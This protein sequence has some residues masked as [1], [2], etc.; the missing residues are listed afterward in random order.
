MPNALTGDFEAVLEVSGGTLDRLLATM[1]Q[2]AFVNA[3]KPSLPHDAYFRIGDDSHVP[4]VRGSVAA[5]IGVPHVEL[6][7]GAADRFRIHVDVRARYRADPGSTPLADIIHGTVRAEYQFEDIDP[8]CFGWRGIA[9]EYLWMRVIKDS[10]SFDGILRNESSILSLIS[11]L[12][13]Q[14]V[15]ARVEKLLATLLDIRFAPTPQPIGKQFRHLRS[16]AFGGGSGQSGIAM[17]FGLSSEK[18]VGDLASINNL[19]LGGHDFGIAVSRE[20]IISSIQPKLDPLVGLQRDFHVHGDAGVG[21]G[22]EIDYHVRLDSTTAEWAGP[23]AIPF[24]PLSGGLIRIR[25]SGVGWASRLYRSGVFNVGS[26]RASDLRMSFTVEQLLLLGFDEGSERLTVTTFGTPVVTLNYNGP[27]SGIMN[28][29]ARNAITTQVQ[30]HLAGPVTHAQNDLAFLTAPG[31]KAALI[32]QLR[33]IDDAAGARFNEAVFHGEGLILRGTIP[34]SYRHAPHVSFEKTAAADGFDAIESWFPGGRVDTFEWTWRW[35]TNGIEAPPSPPGS[36]SPED[37]FTLRRPQGPRSRFGVSQSREQP[38]PGLDGQGRVCLVIRGVHVDH[39]TGALIPVESVRECA[40]FGYEFRMPYEIGAYTR[41]YDPLRAVGERPAPEIGVMRVGVP[42]VRDHASN[43]L[44]LYLGDAWNE[45]AVYTLRT[46]LERCRREG[47]GL[48]VLVLFRDGVLRAGDLGLQSRLRDLGEGLAAPM[49]TSEDV[50]Q[51]W[52]T[53]LG[54]SARGGQ[55]AWRLITPD[56]VVSWSHHGRADAELLASVL[57]ERLVASGP[58]GFGRMR[59]EVG[60]AE[61]VPIELMTQHCPPVPLS[62]LGMSGSKLVFIHKDSS[63]AVAQLAR[64][65]REY[66]DRAED[67]AFVAIVIAGANAEEAEALR[68]EM[69][70]DIPTFPDP[71][72][73]LT[74]RAGVRLSPS[75][76]T[77]DDLGRLVGFEMGVNVTDNSSSVPPDAAESLES[78]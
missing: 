70:L 14:T 53:V 49:Q 77:L 16:L 62:R 76:L 6:I 47:A 5:Q 44:V 46:G 13:E 18:P 3:G 51:G 21:G 61:L 27:F 63:S 23:L 72:G 56:G 31:R 24:V 1:H 19:F 55:P 4:G 22:L 11:V 74:R 29:L 32:D 35:F 33:R 26:V 52:S 17:P 78:S 42:E 67:Q 54:L 41:L 50:R 64:L 48:L 7:H 30:S 39:I 15:K 2:N 71:N 69:N 28:P 65:R 25:V 73:T 36:S 38:L 59:S 75:T 43:T 8:T 12:D 9:A 20:H 57:D 10:V 58:A 37:T 45:E 68:T 60:I 66:A 40:Q 34:L